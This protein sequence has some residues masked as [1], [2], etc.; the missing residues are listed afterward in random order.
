MLETF[1][2]FILISVV[3]SSYKII[4]KNV[5]FLL[6]LEKLREL[7]HKLILEIGHLLKLLWVWLVLGIKG[8]LIH[9]IIIF[10]KRVKIKNINNHYESFYNVIIFIEII[11]L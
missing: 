7:L 11:L 5:V 10:I 6:R 9:I 4:L 2:N 3:F 1:C 8:L